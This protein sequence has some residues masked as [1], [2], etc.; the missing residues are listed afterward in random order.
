M[1][2]T[3][4]RSHHRKSWKRIHL[5]HCTDCP[6]PFVWRIRLVPNVFDCGLIEDESLMKYEDLPDPVESA[7][8]AVAALE[9]AVD[10]LMSVVKELKALEVE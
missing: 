3:P 1:S 5:L 10:L 6:K 9:E 2:R 4:N 7:E 8:E